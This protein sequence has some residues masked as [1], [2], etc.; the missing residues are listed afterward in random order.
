[1]P[2]VHDCARAQDAQKLEPGKAFEREI[3]KGQEHAYR[4]SLVAGQFV[5]VVVEPK[6]VD[7]AIALAA[8]GGKQVKALDTKDSLTSYELPKA[9]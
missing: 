6:S 1:M 2:A 4:I 7:L 8:P 9:S 3:G 5:R